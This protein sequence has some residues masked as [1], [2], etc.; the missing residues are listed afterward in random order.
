MCRIVGGIDFRNNSLTE[1]V[2]SRMRDV[3]AH[4]GP[5]SKGIYIDGKVVLAHRRLSIIDVSE[6]G[7]Q[8]MQFGKLVIT[9]N[10]EIYN[11]K[12]I[13][14]ELERLG[15]GFKTNGDTEVIVRAFEYWGHS[16]VDRFRGMFA[17][18]IWDTADK[19][20]TL[21]R[22]RF[23]VKPIY[24][25]YKDGLFMFSSELKSFHQH[26]N[27][28]KTIDLEGIP[29]FLL[30]GYFQE[31]D[32]I[33]KYVNKVKPGT[34]LTINSSGEVTEKTYWD[35]NKSYLEAKVQHLNLN[36]YEERLEEILT[37]SFNLRMVA[38]VPVGIF[39]SGGIDS[40]LVSA[41]IQKSTNKQLHTFTIGFEDRNY[42]ESAIAEQ[43]ANKLGTK[44]QTL[45]CSE[46]DFKEVIPKLPFIFDEPF[47]DSSSIPTYL[48]SKFT[49][50]S[51]KVA[52]SGDGGDELFG[53]YSKYKF[54]NQYNKFLKVPK[55]IRSGIQEIAYLCS[56]GLFEKFVLYSGNKSYAQLGSKYLK[57]RQT[58]GAKD[59]VQMFEFASSFLS[60]KELKL[61]SKIKYNK[62][63]QTYDVSNTDKFLTSMGY[64]D[65]L[66]YLPGDILTKVDRA[67]MHNALET[68]EPFLDPEILDF[69]FSLP[70]NMKISD[71][72]DTKFLLKRLLEKYIPIDII[73]RPK[74]GFTIPIENWMRNHLNQEI[75]EMLLDTNF[76]ITFQLDQKNISLECKGFF[77]N[78]SK[79]NPH[80]IWFIYTLYKWYELWL[81]N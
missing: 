23:G 34:F 66:S 27:F 70:S 32:C 24:W 53:G 21:C 19:V 13:R 41:I 57:L 50:K 75:N 71:K 8:P 9:Y 15:I 11:Y 44:H 38:D 37:K 20:L 28:D 49:S 43:I 67:S 2:V 74:Y 14:I 26:P 79:L 61:I 77:T 55:L 1:T 65:M 56:P 45:N 73:N 25:Y 58:I 59:T 39:L 62:L 72:G 18:A 60:E 47:G 4:G 76:F 81:K 12:E 51:V 52:L 35:V 29:H 30:K 80:V 42:D 33:F 69:S 3:L 36:E 78:Q 5:D 16:A 7:N 6:S 40:S 64:W 68:R 31:K 63:D 54:I 48:L 17:F 22:D 46:E 10:G